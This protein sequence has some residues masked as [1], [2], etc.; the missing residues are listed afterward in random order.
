[1]ACAQA[2][3][4]SGAGEVEAAVVAV[5]AFE[6]LAHAVDFGGGKL[7]EL[8]DG[9]AD[10]L[11]VLGG[12]VAEVGEECRYQAFLAEIFDAQGFYLAHILGRQ[13]VDLGTQ[14][15][16]LVNHKLL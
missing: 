11:L 14:A 5:R 13:A 8:V 15:V 16:Y 2:Y 9:R 1:M 7:F 6:S 3:V 4:G 10:R 12:D